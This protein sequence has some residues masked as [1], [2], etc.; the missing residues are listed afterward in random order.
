MCLRDRPHCGGYGLRRRLHPH[1]H[2]AEHNPNA[3]DYPLVV[4]NGIRLRDTLNNLDVEPDS[5]TLDDLYTERNTNGV[6]HG[7]RKQH[8]E[9]HAHA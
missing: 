6:H 1:V 8:G 5:D 3:I 2:D 9:Q 4:D 7:E